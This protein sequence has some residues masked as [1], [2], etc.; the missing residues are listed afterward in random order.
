MANG[1]NRTPVSFLAAPD[2]GEISSWPPPSILLDLSHFLLRRSQLAIATVS[3]YASSS[4][5]IALHVCHTLGTRV[6]FPGSA[7]AS[8]L[9]SFPSLLFL[10]FILRFCISLFAFFSSSL[11]FS[12]CLFFS[13]SRRAARCYYFASFLRDILCS[14]LSFFAPSFFF[15]FLLDLSLSSCGFPGWLLA[16]SSPSLNDILSS[17]RSTL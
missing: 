1:M 13:H 12:W 10:F 11:S 3:L 9:A 16:L 14:C 4:T 6:P 15:F 8:S 5:V 17:T 2:S 7:L